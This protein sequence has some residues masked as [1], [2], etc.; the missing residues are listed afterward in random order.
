[1]NR[2]INNFLLRWV[3]NSHENTSQLE[4][5]FHFHFSC[6]NEL[7]NLNIWY[8]QN[9]EPRLWKKYL[10]NCYNWYACRCKPINLK[11]NMWSKDIVYFSIQKMRKKSPC[12]TE[13]L[14]MPHRIHMILNSLLIPWI[15]RIVL[16]DCSKCFK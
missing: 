7:W 2:I 11:W 14:S 6:F 12:P 13:F 5:F 9:K 4:R 1:M 10:F 3:N 16:M 8:G 15:S